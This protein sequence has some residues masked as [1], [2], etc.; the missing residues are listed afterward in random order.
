M[1]EKSRIIYSTKTKIVR[2]RQIENNVAKII[3]QN[4][5]ILAMNLML[6]KVYSVPMGTWDVKAD[7]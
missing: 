6:L 4:E 3:E 5:K 2:N 7:E 1:N